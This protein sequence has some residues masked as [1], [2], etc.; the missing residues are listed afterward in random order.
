MSRSIWLAG[1][2]GRGEDQ[3][4]GCMEEVKEGQRKEQKQR[5][6]LG[7]EPEQG[8]EQELSLEDEAVIRSRYRDTSLHLHMGEKKGPVGG[9]LQFGEAGV[10]IL[11]R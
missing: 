4:D 2:I 10:A 1:D 6:E 9:W 3:G 11:H 7:K 5:Q 8:K